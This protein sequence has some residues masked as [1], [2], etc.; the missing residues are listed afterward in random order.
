MYYDGLTGLQLTDVLGLKVEGR[1]QHGALAGHGNN[2]LILIPECRTDAPGVAH[3]EHLAATGQSAHHVAAVVMLHGCA[4]H[5]GHFHVVVN[6]V[7]DVC[8]LESFVFRLH[9]QSLHLAVQTV[10]HQFECD[11]GVAV[12][13]R[14][15][16]LRCQKIKDLVDVG[17]V[18]VAAQTE[19]LGAPVVTAQ[20]WMNERQ[21]AFASRRIAQVSHQQLTLHLLR[22][23]TE[24]LRDGIL[25]LSLFTEHILRSGLVS[26]THRGDTC[27]L[28]TAVVLLLHHQ[29]EFV[30]AVGPGAVFLFVIRQRFQQAN[31]RHT[32]FML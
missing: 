8:A 12:D 27:S 2:F 16:A 13:A 15:L 7:G 25:A 17:H 26:E 31:H 30:E 5:V 19:V 21:S 14:R 28:L 1:L 3:G 11:V 10:A 20:E 29:I 4:Q 23:T 32:T 9:E 22:H 6:V 24:N 18:K